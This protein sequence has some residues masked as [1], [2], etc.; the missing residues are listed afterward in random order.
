MPRAASLPAET[1][2]LIAGIINLE[3]VDRDLDLQAQLVA[4]K[5][6]FSVW[7]ISSIATEYDFFSERAIGS[8]VSFQ[9]SSRPVATT[10]EARFVRHRRA[11]PGRDRSC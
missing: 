7:A 4:I 2:R 1:R 8:E 11:E 6:L 3:W 5:N 10:P 9:K